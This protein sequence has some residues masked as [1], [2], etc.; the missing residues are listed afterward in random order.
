MKKTFKKNNKGGTLLIKDTIFGLSIH[1][2][3]PAQEYKVCENV[4]KNSIILG[5]YSSVITAE[6]LD[7][8]L[9]D[10]GKKQI[11]IRDIGMYRKSGY[12]QYSMQVEFRVNGESKTFK[13][14]S[15]SSQTFDMDDEVE[16]HR[17]ILEAVLN[18]CSEQIEDWADEL[19]SQD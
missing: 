15:T 1:Q 13:S 7:N 3:T 8:L 5:Q 16:Q 12:G 17:I 19:N 2:N 6:E 10:F 4:M 14:H 9:P 18:N 11:H